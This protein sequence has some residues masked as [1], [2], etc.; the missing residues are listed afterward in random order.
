L[1]QRYFP[2]RCGDASPQE[3]LE[4]PAYRKIPAE[5]YFEK[6]FKKELNS[7]VRYL[8]KRIAP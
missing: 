7:G 4:P 3:R 8:T 5:K 2:S 1:K 6:I